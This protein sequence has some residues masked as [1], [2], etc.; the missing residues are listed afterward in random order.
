MIEDRIGTEWY[1]IR[2]RLNENEVKTLIL[3]LNRLYEIDCWDNC[4]D[5][6]DIYVKGLHC[7]PL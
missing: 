1:D 2:I 6:S 3:R 7:Y 5:K 4:L